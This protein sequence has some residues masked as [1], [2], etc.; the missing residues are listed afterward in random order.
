MKK[1]FLA[2]KLLIIVL[3]FLIALPCVLALTIGEKTLTITNK[4][5]FY[6]TLKNLGNGV[7]FYLIII[8]ILLIII[9]FSLNPP[10][11]GGKNHIK[12]LISLISLISL[13]F[14][15]MYSYS[16]L[17]KKSDIY[18]VNCINS[19]F[20][21]TTK[22]TKKEILNYINEIQIKVLNSQESNLKSLNWEEIKANIHYNNLKNIHEVQNYLKEIFL[23]HN[24]IKI[25]NT[26]T[27]TLSFVQTLWDHKLSIL[28]FFLI[29]FGLL[30]IKKSL[31]DAALQKLAE[32]SEL[33]EKAELA[34]KAALAAKADLT[35]ELAAAE[36]TDARLTEAIAKELTKLADLA[37]PAND[38]AAAELTDLA[39]TTNDVTET[40]TELA[41]ELL[42][43]ELFLSE[44]AFQAL[45]V[46]ETLLTGML[47]SLLDNHGALVHELCASQNKD[48]LLSVLNQLS[49]V[50]NRGP[51]VQDFVNIT[52]NLLTQALSTLSDV[53]DFPEL[54]VL[55][56]MPDFPF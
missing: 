20:T 53:P 49:L 33:A 19:I 18:G 15:N 46:K 16:L 13:Y 28:A 21:L 25:T 44:D 35:N 9:F 29:L 2:L 11:G 51:A 31:A 32:K 52:S 54:P 38:V 22:L 50:K 30:Y 26:P 45:V 37:A 17:I 48:V 34:A 43:A 1:V 14:C 24:N 4:F 10:K 47:N 3:T 42:A 40:A 8:L 55:P 5:V 56:E 7:F 39:A 36:L 41:T 12:S 27:E 6:L 23:N